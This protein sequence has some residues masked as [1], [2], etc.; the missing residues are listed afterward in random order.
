M[1]G[2]G[3]DDHTLIRIVVTRSE[4]DL[5]DIKQEFL[6]QYGQ[7]L[8]RWIEVRRHARHTLS[9]A[10]FRYDATTTSLLHIF[11]AFQGDTLGHY[12]K[13]LLALVSY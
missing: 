7:T 9:R 3:T 5:G 2:L 6:A 8:E 1:K 12:R 13:M 4:I 11:L 10:I